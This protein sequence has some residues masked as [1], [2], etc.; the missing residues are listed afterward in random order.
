MLTVW[1]LGCLGLESWCRG[2]GLGLETWCLDPSFGL[3]D[4]YL[5]ITG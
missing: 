4:C 2:L 3:E 5:N 1:C